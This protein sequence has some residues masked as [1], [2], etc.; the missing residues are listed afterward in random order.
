MGYNSWYDFE[1]NV[2]AQDLMHVADVMSE[3][4]LQYLGYEYINLDEFAL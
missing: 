4:G 3:L 2:N 1:C